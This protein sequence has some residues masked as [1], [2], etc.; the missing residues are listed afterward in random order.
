ME[1]KEILL[2]VMIGFLVVT[3]AI[4]SL[5]LVTLSNNPVVTTAVQSA[6][7]ASVNPVKSTVSHAASLEN[8]PSM[9]GGC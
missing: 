6:Q 7:S 1:T 9:V 5:Q 8:L 2:I 3:T 4:Q